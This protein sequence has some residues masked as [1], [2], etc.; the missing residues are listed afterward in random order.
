AQKIADG[1][2]IAEKK[3]EIE[4]EWGAATRA[5]TAQAWAEAR[6]GYDRVLALCDEL[7]KLD[8]ARRAADQA[9]ATSQNARQ[10]AERAGAARDAQTLFNGAESSAREAGTNYDKADYAG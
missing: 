10:E 9:R 7:V 5:E 1:P 6:R 8:E 3:K 4:K 2:G